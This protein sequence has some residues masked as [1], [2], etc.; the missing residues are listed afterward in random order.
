MVPDQ[1]QQPVQREGAPVP[2]VEL[3]E[4]FRHLAHQT[5]LRR[6]DATV[7]PLGQEVVAQQRRVYERLHDAVHEAGGPEIQQ[8]AQSQSTGLGHCP[9]YRM[10]LEQTN[11]RAGGPPT[12]VRDGTAQIPVER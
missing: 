4:Q 12:R 10:R 6:L 3:L 7:V 11:L 2:V 9:A 5:T 1:V 8:S